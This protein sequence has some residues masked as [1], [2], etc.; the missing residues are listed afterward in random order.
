MCKA[1]CK[2]TA[3]PFKYKMGQGVSH[4]SKSKRAVTE[5]ERRGVLKGNREG[6]CDQ[7]ILHIHVCKAI[8][9]LFT[10]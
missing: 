2:I 4:V 1:V 8:I 7:N 10:S 5:E 3:Y 6:E 9:K